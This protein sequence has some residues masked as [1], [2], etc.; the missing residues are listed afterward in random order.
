MA[1]EALGNIPLI[2]K[3]MGG[4]RGAG[5]RGVGVGSLV[6]AGEAGNGRQANGEVVAVAF[7]AGSETGFCGRSGHGAQ[8]SVLCPCTP[9]GGVPRPV[10]MAGEATDLGYSPG[11]RGILGGTVASDA[12]VGVLRE[13]RPVGFQPV[14]RMLSRRTD[15]RRRI[16]P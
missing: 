1:L 11:E 15:L 4:S 16:V 5:P 8:P 6:M 13:F 14:G 10:E 12:L 2:G 3:V 7:E 9:S